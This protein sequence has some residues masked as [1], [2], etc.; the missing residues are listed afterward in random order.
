MEMKFNATACHCL[1]RAVD[2]IQTREQTQEVRLPDAM[3]DIGRVLGSWGQVLIRGK[4][5]RS[6]SMSVSGGV[7]A[8]VLYAPEDG[9]E[10]RTLETWMPFQM[11]WDVP[12][13]ERDGVICVLPRLK[14]IDA[15]STSARK[16]MVR[17]NVSIWGQALELTEPEICTPGELPEDVQILTNVYPMDLPR[18]SGEKIFQIDEELTL[19]ERDAL[20]EKILHYGMDILTAEQKVMASRLVFRGVGMLHM[21][22]WADGK[23]CSW[24]CE[25]PF[26]QFADLDQDHSASASARVI[27]VLTNLELDIQERRLLLK[28]GV[29]AQYTVFDRVMVELAEDA[30]SP[31]R[32]LQISNQALDLPQR[33]D[34]RR[35]NLR[36]SQTIRAEAE[37]IVETCWLPD[38]AQQRQNGD[39][40]RIVMPGQ[41][42][43]LYYDP[44]GNL[45]C[46][47]ARYEQE[48]ELNAD[49][50]TV[51][52]V[53]LTAQ[54]RPQVTAGENPEVS[55]DYR[56]EI[57]VYSP[58]VQWM[59][60]G[61]ELG[62][63]TAPDP[64]RPSVILRRCSDRL[65]DTA[66]ACG[67]TVEAIR[68]AN[69]LTEESEK[70]KLLLIPVS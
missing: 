5:W 52:D 17:A 34:Q 28:C 48:W 47:S 18:E 50:D 31:R 30:Y 21:L 10:P 12:E 46:S 25:V 56:M 61:L 53:F 68:K 19:P 60:T 3:P 43:V 13:T 58:G 24:D 44:A 49:G 64:G 14:S 37:R 4:E 63:I 1:R 70:G 40:V 69:H 51:S 66:K 33:L 23:L 67:S 7:M 41:L 32:S 9:S 36:T 54:G 6:G 26:S 27:P 20:P 59:V 16:L 45:Q 62:E 11:K 22:Y 15:R 29:A 8:W 65:W 57:D 42:Q 55:M 39:T 35:E 38:V 2:Q